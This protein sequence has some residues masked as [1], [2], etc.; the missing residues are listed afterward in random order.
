MYIIYSAIVNEYSIIYEQN[1]NIG[2]LV[3][4]VPI[5]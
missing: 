4:R 1:M 5:L 2:T 3:K